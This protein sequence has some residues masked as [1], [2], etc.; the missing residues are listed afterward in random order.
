MTNLKLIRSGQY[1]IEL[2]LK[3]TLYLNR[4]FDKND[5][6]KEEKVHEN[7]IDLVESDEED[8]DSWANSAFVSE[9][10]ESSELLEK[11]ESSDGSESPDFGIMTDDELIAYYDAHNSEII[12]VDC[13][14]PYYLNNYIY[15][16]YMKDSKL[17]VNGKL[18]YKLDAWGDDKLRI[19]T[20]M[21]MLIIDFEIEFNTADV[22]LG[23]ISILNTKVKANMNNHISCNKPLT[24]IINDFVFIP[25][26]SNTALPKNVKL[27]NSIKEDAFNFSDLQYTNYEWKPKPEPFKW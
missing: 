15:D 17:V 20:S 26:T 4:F 8:E 16:Y 5:F 13:Y 21:K 18:F 24:A 11:S 12:E 10:P 22:N 25:F 19:N 3:N 6:I 2:E 23:H 9:S 7:V 1:L 14:A 27:I